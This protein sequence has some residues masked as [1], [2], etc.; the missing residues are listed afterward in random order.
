MTDL[1]T[2]AIPLNKLERLQRLLTENRYFA[3][4][5]LINEIMQNARSEYS[6]G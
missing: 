1:L 5:V 3:A 6:G 4:Q 2:I